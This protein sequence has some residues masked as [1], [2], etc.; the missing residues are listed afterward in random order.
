[1]ADLSRPDRLQVMLNSEEIRAVDDWRFA[2]RLPS[3][4]AAVRELLRRGL[5]VD[6]IAI[7][8]DGRQSTSFGVVDEAA[9]EHARPSIGDDAS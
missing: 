4:A 9:A 6:G 3:R 1:M 7:D 2:N 8:T 5:A